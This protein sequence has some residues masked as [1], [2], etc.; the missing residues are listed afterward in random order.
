MHHV[1]GAE[2]HDAVQDDESLALEDAED[3]DTHDPARH[4]DHGDGH[5]DL[6]A[7][8]EAAQDDVRLVHGADGDTD[9]HDLEHATTTRV[10]GTAFK[11]LL[12][13][14]LFKTT[15]ELMKIAIK[16]IKT[17][18]RLSIN[19]SEVGSFLFIKNTKS[20]TH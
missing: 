6:G 12:I 4:H 11:E 20:S 14:T 8:D 18:N 16:L 3:A 15:K 10:M 19:L 17:A 5:H 1:Q 9:R 13:E 2:A 7:A